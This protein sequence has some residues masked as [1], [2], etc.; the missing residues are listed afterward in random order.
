MADGSGEADPLEVAL[1]HATQP[2]EADSQLDPTPIMSELMDL[3]NDHVADGSQMPLH[4]LPRK[5]SLEGLRSG[6]QDIRRDC[7]LLASFG[8]GCIAMPYRDREFCSFNEMSKPI[9]HVS[10]QSA[11]R[12]YIQCSNAGSATGLERLQDGQQDRFSFSRPGR[13]YNKDVRSGSDA[14][15]HFDL[16]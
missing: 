15:N 1:R 8:R 11:Q 4:K 2:L 16:H 7:G 6:D 12:S 10:I 3:V 13:R 9:D 5:D 14:R